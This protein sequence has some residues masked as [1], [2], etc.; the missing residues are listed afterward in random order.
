MPTAIA[1]DTML[2]RSVTAYSAKVREA[3]LAQ[4]PG[5]SVCSPLGVW[6]LLCACLRA[7]EDPEREELEAVVGCSQSEA[8]V[9]L[10]AFLE[11]VPSAIQVALALWAR[12]EVL[13]DQLTAWMVALPAAIDRGAIPTQQDANTW[14]ESNTFGLI[15]EFPMS[16]ERFDLVL[17]SALATQISWRDPYTVALASETFA[18]S[19]PWA[20]AV[21]RVLWTD[22]TWR[23]AIVDTAAAGVVAVHQAIAREELVVI[24]VSADPAVP[25]VDVLAAAHEINERANANNELPR[26][27]LFDIPLGQGHSWTIDEREREAQQPGQRFET[28]S[29]VALPAWWIESRLK[30][31]ASPAFGAKTA[32]RVLHDLI[33]DGPDDSRQVAL[34]QFDRYGFKAAAVTGIAVACALV[35]NNE[36]GVER[37]AE[38]RFDHPFAAI[39]VCREPW[40]EPT[41]FR[42]LP[43]FEAWVDAPTDVPAEP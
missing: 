27:S 18:P 10:D 7:A 6:L 24:C 41:R 37:I 42:G 28:I 22:R 9:L 29:G 19:S 20:G 35:I 15:R 39:A 30:L 1:L 33:G 12:D 34:A 3:V 16:V 36:I 14:A 40:G 43:V 5:A 21:R 8:S 2:V 31:L 17:A 23:S 26:R 25:R 13:T 4:H 38:L 32:T 11:S